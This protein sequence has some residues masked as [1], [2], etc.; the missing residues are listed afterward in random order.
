MVYGLI[1]LLVGGIFMIFHI[2]SNYLTLN[3]VILWVLCVITHIL[4]SF[5]LISQN[6]KKKKEP[7]KKKNK[8]IR[9][10]IKYKK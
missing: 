10:H 8:D 5:D 9:T 3:P 6:L 2:I 1:P 4:P 7:K